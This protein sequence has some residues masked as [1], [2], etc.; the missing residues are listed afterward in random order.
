MAE[1]TVYTCDRCGREFRE[2]AGKLWIQTDRV[3][4]AAGSMEDVGLTVDVCPAC[5]VKVLA[6][7]AEHQY[8]G[9]TLHLA[10]MFPK[11]GG[12]T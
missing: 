2:G 11:A 12:K 4:D 10:S 3:C 9:Q 5:A 6:S 1:R 8:R 7:V